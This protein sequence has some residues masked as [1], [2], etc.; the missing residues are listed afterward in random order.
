MVV[1]LAA[2]LTTAMPPQPVTMEAKEAEE[3]AAEELVLLTV[4]MTM[5][6]KLVEAEA[7]ADAAEGN[8]SD[9]GNSAEADVHDGGEGAGAE[10]HH[11]R[12]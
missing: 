1:A 3:Q 5:E 9:G 6:A 10:A 4:P 7:I 12:C 11:W 8:D 2:M